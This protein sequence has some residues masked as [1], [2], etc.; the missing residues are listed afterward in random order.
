M[1]HF[2]LTVDGDKVPVDAQSTTKT[3]TQKDTN[4]NKY[5]WWSVFL[6]FT[7]W[8]SVAQVFK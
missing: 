7:L 3:T 2:V 5:P 4:S 6:T 1:R 8:I